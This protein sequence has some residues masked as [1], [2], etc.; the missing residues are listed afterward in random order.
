MIYFKKLKSGNYRISDTE[1]FD[2]Y[3]KNLD[4]LK[5]FYDNCT[6]RIIKATY[7]QSQAYIKSFSELLKKLNN[8][9]H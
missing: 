9:K 6:T 1:E 5:K 4:E 2:V 8:G 7:S 3:C